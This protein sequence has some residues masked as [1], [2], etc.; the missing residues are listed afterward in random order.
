ML[1]LI[2]VFI[3]ILAADVV[4]PVLL[5]AQIYA[6]GSKKPKRNSIMV[7][8]GWFVIYFLSGIL[9]AIG[10][11]SI[12]TF[13]HNPRPIDFYIEIV[14]AALLIVFGLKFLLKPN[15]KQEKKGY[16]D[17][18][19]LTGWSAFGMGA[20]INLTGLPFA[21]PYF[22]ALDQ[23]LKADFG[24]T[25]SLLALLIYNLLYIAPFVAITFL[26]II[27]GDRSAKLFE[28]INDW[29]ERIGTVILPVMMIA[30]AAALIIDAYLY[31][32]TGV[33]WF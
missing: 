8:L 31:F 14:V 9:L 18:S 4:N 29:M 12:M 11:E 15:K 2:L 7:L 3:P 27:L 25:E 17:T 19:T 28:Q 26:K 20:T 21:I 33:P 30:I 6:L 22:A 1:Q 10:L 24:W 5:A 16:G 13:I 32:T 23:I